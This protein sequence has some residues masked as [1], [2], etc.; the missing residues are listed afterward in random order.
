MQF[1]VYGKLKAGQVIHSV[2]FFCNY[3]SWWIIG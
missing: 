3:T 1:S 2:E